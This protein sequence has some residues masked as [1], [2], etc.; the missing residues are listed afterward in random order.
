[1]GFEHLPQRARWATGK[2]L[3]RA[4]SLTEVALADRSPVRGK[5]E[6]HRLGYAGRGETLDERF[7]VYGYSLDWPS[8]YLAQQ[9]RYIV[10]AERF[11]PGDIVGFILVVIGS[12]YDGGRCGAVLARDVGNFPSPLLWTSRPVA[13]ACAPAG[14]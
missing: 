2:V 14:T 3:D 10:L 9:R 11:R 6:T 5:L 8:G 7:V 4:G 1:V 13:I 12:E